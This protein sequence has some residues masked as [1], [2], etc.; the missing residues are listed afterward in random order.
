MPRCVRVEPGPGPDCLWRQM[1]LDPAS[2]DIRSHGQ[3]RVGREIV[4]KVF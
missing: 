3:V 2:Q 1:E 4:E